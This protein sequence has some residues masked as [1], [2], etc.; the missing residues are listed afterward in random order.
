MNKKSRKSFVSC[1]IP[2]YNEEK[3]VAGVVKVCLKVPQIKEV[4]VVNDGSKDKTIKKLQPLKDKI[5]IISYPKNQGKGH[6]VAQGIKASQFDYL[7]FLDA[8]LINLQPYHLSSLIQPVLS[9]Q[10]DMTIGV[11]AS[12]E[13]P[14]YS[15]WPFSGQRCLRK[16]LIQK[17][18]NK[19]EKSGYGLEV[20]LNSQMKKKRIVIVPLFSQKPLHI[21]KVKKQKDWLKAYVKEIFHVFHQTIANQKASYQKKMKIKFVRRLASYFKINY[22]RLK[23]YLLEDEE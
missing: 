20:L 7:L 22:Q 23:D 3:T 4:I 16:K 10:V 2:A 9:N 17:I 18:I 1:I 8:D 19:I 5:K 15:G 11:A 21:Q 6:A 12:F 13:N 14:Y